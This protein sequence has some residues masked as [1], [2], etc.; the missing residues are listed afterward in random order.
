M[1]NMV[2]AEN[3]V[4][5]GHMGEVVP[6]RAFIKNVKFFL[7]P[8]TRPQLTL[9]SVDFRSVHPKMCFGF[10]CVLLGLVCPV[11]QIFPF[12]PKQTFSM[13]E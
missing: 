6:L 9:R 11:G 10:G 8:S 12:L 2:T 7:V 13:A 5:G 1:Q 3:G 4:W